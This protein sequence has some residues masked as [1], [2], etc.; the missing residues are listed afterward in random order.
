MLREI[1]RASAFLRNAE[2]GLMLPRGQSVDQFSYGEAFKKYSVSSRQ[3]FISIRDLSAYLGQK[4]QNADG[5]PDKDTVEKACK[6]WQFLRDNTKSILAETDRS[7][8]EADPKEPAYATL[9]QYRGLVGAYADAADMPGDL[10]YASGVRADIE[11]DLKGGDAAPADLAFCEKAYQD[12]GE[13]KSSVSP[14]VT[15]YLRF[16]NDGMKSLNVSAELDKLRR[17]CA[18]ARG[19]MS[20]ELKEKADGLPTLQSVEEAISDAKRAA[21]PLPDDP[22]SVFPDLQSTVREYLKAQ[23][24]DGKAADSLSDSMAAI[25]KDKVSGVRKDMSISDR[26]ASLAMNDPAAE[27][28]T[29]RQL[30][31]LSTRCEAAVDKHAELTESK[32]EAQFAFEKQQ[33]E[34]LVDLERIR[35][36]RLDEAKQA[37]LINTFG[38]QL[39]EPRRNQLALYRLQK[40]DALRS[41]LKTMS[42]RDAMKEGK[43]EST[44]FAAFKKS[45]QRAVTGGS[46]SDLI[47]KAGQYVASVT[48][49]GEEPAADRDKERVALARAAVTMAMPIEENNKA[50]DQAVSGITY[51]KP[52]KVSIMLQPE[53]VKADPAPEKAAVVE[54]PEAEAAAEK[55]AEPQ[56]DA[57]KQAEPQPAVKTDKAASAGK[58]EYPKKL[59]ITDEMLIKRLQETYGKKKLPP[60]LEQN[61]RTMYK[62]AAAG[63]T[64][65]DL[66]CGQHTPFKGGDQVKDLV[67]YAMLCR[68]VMKGPI[69][70]NTLALYSNPNCVNLTRKLTGSSQEMVYLSEYPHDAAYWRE[71]LFTREGLRAA[72]D[73][74]HK[75]MMAGYAKD[76][77]QAYVN[78]RADAKARYEME[79]SQ[80]LTAAKAAKLAKQANVKSALLP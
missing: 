14:A 43:A 76:R 24:L 45:M 52:V 48:E 23:G 78:A 79:K 69:P 80:N 36:L 32:K 25:A 10:Q 1:D 37:L 67:N 39:S 33:D 2:N 56:P 55:Q 13:D 20:P 68:I 77:K 66:K 72:T 3:F 49:N 40:T 8:G 31:E 16:A 63:F 73:T 54:Q 53:P 58:Q 75:E 70:K 18:D 50:F 4:E 38:R 28:L 44:A 59:R 35:A 21:V 60:Q 12:A 46:L 17:S 29:I 27:G 41:H 9:V 47:E 26:I 64:D 34:K 7:L 42:E 11:K 30:K 51:P 6:A 15:S 5:E 74:Y 57:E 71:H 65:L 19:Q 61:I 62:N 22:S